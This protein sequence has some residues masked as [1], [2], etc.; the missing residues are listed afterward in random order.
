MKVKGLSSALRRTAGPSGHHEGTVQR[1]QEQRGQRE[2]TSGSLDR[3]PALPFKLRGV[4]RTSLIALLAVAG[5]APVAAAQEEGVFFDPDTPAGK[6]YAIPLD[7]AR[8]DAGGAERAGRGNEAGG[9]PLF[10]V[11]IERA[12]DAAKR[13]GDGSASARNGT[14]DVDQRT[15]NGEGPSIGERPATG[16]RPPD[17]DRL[18]GGED[19]VQDV[20]GAVPVESTAGGSDSLL[21]AG[22]AAVVLAVGLLVGFG[23]R[24]L[25]RSP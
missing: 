16:E 7:Q 11:G 9:E 24:K 13:V 6:E 2:R 19:A 10:G 22:I 14:A 1:P 25:L 8:R 12:D 17:S 15:P 20:R 18:R 3:S 4:I 5:P 23:L 21:T